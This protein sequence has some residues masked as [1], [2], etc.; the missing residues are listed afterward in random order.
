MYAYG[1]QPVKSWEKG[2]R[3]VSRGSPACLERRLFAR[4]PGAVAKLNPRPSIQWIVRDPGAAAV[5]SP[6]F[7]VGMW[8]KRAL[9]AKA[10]AGI[11]DRYPVPTGRWAVRKPVE[12]ART[13][14]YR[15]SLLALLRVV[16]TNREFCPGEVPFSSGL[17]ANR[18]KRN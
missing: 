2:E 10:C 15:T 12:T 4:T 3:Q 13:T 16:M 17:A 5:L 6:L 8:K 9:G 1:G 14:G 11:P 7:T 18:G